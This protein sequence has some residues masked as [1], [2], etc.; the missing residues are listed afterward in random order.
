MPVAGTGC[1]SMLALALS[2]AGCGAGTGPGVEIVVDTLPDGVVHVRNP[3]IPLLHRADFW[4]AEE[5]ARIGDPESSGAASFVDIADLA[6]DEAGRVYVLDQG[7][8]EIRV[9]DLED[10][11]KH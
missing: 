2:L 5:V 7:A 3:T 8:G 1:M 9:F 11:K 6:L 4:R 10:D